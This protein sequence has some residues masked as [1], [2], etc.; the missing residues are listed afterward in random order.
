M[1]RG[2]EG[3]GFPDRPLASQFDTIDHRHYTI[4]AFL[5]AIEG[6]VVSLDV[7][8]ATHADIGLLTM[9]HTVCIIG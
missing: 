7:L 3:E 1:G 4:H 8:S 2:I 9:C 5:S 6:R